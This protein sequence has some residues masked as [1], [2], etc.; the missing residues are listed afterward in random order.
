MDHHTLSATPVRVVGSRVLRVCRRIVLKPSTTLCRVKFH[1]GFWPNSIAESQ[2]P[3]TGQPRNPHATHARPER[4]R[5][6]PNSC[7]S[8]NTV[9]LEL[10]TSKLR[11]RVGPSLDRPDPVG[12]EDMYSLCACTCVQASAAFGRAG[13]RARRWPARGQRGES[14]GTACRGC[15]RRLGW[16][17]AAGG[18]SR[19]QAPRSLHTHRRRGSP[20]RHRR[21]QLR[22]RLPPPPPIDVARCGS[23]SGSRSNRSP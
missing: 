2:L 13:I 23:A 22:E 1:G 3:A 20:G 18:C 10:P 5:P 14:R 16:R 12:N 7:H 17:S 11:D 21:H 9:V 4:P 6:I 8:C 19:A 15:R